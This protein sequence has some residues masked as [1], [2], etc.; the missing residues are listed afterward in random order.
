MR[1]P[2]IVTVA[3]GGHVRVPEGAFAFLGGEHIWEVV[4][5][6]ENGAVVGR[7][8]AMGVEAPDLL[9]LAYILEAS[10]VEDKDLSAPREVVSYVAATFTGVSCLCTDKGG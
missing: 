4:L 5:A 1:V 8:H 3:V 2:A 10:A 7:E 9:F 6:R